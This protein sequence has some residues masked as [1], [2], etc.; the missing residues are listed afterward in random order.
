MYVKIFKLYS[1]CIHVNSIRIK[2]ISTFSNQIYVQNIFIAKI[3]KLFY[4]IVV[5]VVKI[6][7]P[8]Q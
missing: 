2:L 5:V 1:L 6:V 4:K 8:S 7:L 3:L